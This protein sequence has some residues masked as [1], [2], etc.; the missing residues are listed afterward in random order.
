MGSLVLVVLRRGR[1]AGAAEEEGVRTS[2]LICLLTD[3]AKETLPFPLIGTCRQRWGKQM[4]RDH[5]VESL[6]ATTVSSIDA[7]FL[8]ASSLEAR[9]I[10]LIILLLGLS[11]GSDEESRE[12]VTVPEL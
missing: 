10:L 2:H 7:S 5:E 9:G 8:A 1:V 4:R 12:F 11:K 3:V 6:L